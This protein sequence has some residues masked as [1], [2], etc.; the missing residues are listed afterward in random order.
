MGSLTFTYFTTTSGSK[1][2]LIRWATTARPPNSRGDAHTHVDAVHRLPFVVGTMPLSCHNG[3]LRCI[4][5]L[6]P[7]RRPYANWALCVHSSRPLPRW[8]DSKAKSSVQS[9]LSSPLVWYLSEETLAS[10]SAAA[11]ARCERARESEWSVANLHPI[12][13]RTINA[14]F[15]GN[16][17]LPHGGTAW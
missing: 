11:P 3:S 4:S 16:P 14:D 1:K 6:P 7:L 9:S 2:A 12:A 8:T 15:Y 5:S 17:W 13:P 10:A